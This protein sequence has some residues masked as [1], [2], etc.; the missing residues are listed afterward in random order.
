[1]HYF[2]LHGNGNV[3]YIFYHFQDISYRNS[4]L[5]WRWSIELI[6]VNCK[7]T[8]RKRIYDFL[9][10]DNINV[11]HIVHYFQDI[12]Y[13]NMHDLHFDLC[14]SF[15]VRCLYANLKLLH[16]S[17][18]LMA[19][20]MFATSFTTSRIF[21][22]EMYMILTLT[23]IMGQG[24]CIYANRKSLHDFLFDGN[25]CVF[26]NVTIS[27]ISIAKMCM[28]LTLILTLRISQCQM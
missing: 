20:F 11:C 28:T 15:K 27:K 8:N 3:C 4:T 13:G 9:F 18:Y 14:V 2:L 21:A 26:I 23:F 12:C 24:H 6:K 10:D 22:V 1:M 7:Y 25:N 19:I 5:P 16:V 17:W